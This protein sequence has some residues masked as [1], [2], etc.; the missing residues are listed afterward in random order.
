[1]N[2]PSLENL[3]SFAAAGRLLPNKPSPCTMWRWHVHGVRGVKLQTWCIGG[4]RYTSREALE[5]FIQAT[6]AAA[7]TS[8]FP[9]APAGRSAE[10]AAKLQAVGIL[11]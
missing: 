7:S 11:T 1:M 2:A 5:N 4:R 10:T 8:H 6:T 9:D 3:I